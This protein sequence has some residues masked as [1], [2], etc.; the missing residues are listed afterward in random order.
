M[1]DLYRGNV[2]DWAASLAFYSVLSIF[3]LFL[4]GLILLSFVADPG[5]ISERAVA[6]M[7]EFL[8]GGEEQIQRIVE[9]AVAYRG[10]VGIVSAVTFIYTAQ[11]VL[12]A[13]VRGLNHVSDVDPEEDDARRAFAV[14]LALSFGL[15][16]LAVLA[17]ASSRLVDAMWEVLWAIPGPDHL[18]FRA[19][20][21]VVRGVLLFALFALVFSAVPRGKR[22]WRAV[23]VGALASTGAFLAAQGVF[24]LVI[25]GVWQNLSLAYG[26]IALA[27]LL[28]TWAWIVALITLVG[29]GL[30]SHVKVLLIEDADTREST[31]RHLQR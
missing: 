20:K 18:M 19:A 30:A 22:R 29:G 17:L 31:Q 26:Q 5:D 28:M 21:A 25:D 12:G 14:E 7:A 2:L 24:R 16:A 4:V 13:L 11:R 23:A 27:A 3:P 8:P 9:D 10:R 1:R 6:F 15:L